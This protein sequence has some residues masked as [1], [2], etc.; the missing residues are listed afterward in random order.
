MVRSLHWWY[1][2]TC[3]C[4]N[5][6]ILPCLPP[7]TT[8]YSSEIYLYLSSFFS[9]VGVILTLGQVLAHG[10]TG[11]LDP[12]F[13]HGLQ[14]AREVSFGLAVGLNY[15][16]FWHFVE[17]RISETSSRSTSTRPCCADGKRR[18]LLGLVLKWSLLVLILVISVLQ[19]TWRITSGVRFRLLYIS[20]GTIEITVSSLLLLKLILSAS[21][22]RGWHHIRQYI[23]PSL[24][25]CISTGLGVGNLVD[26]RLCNS[27]FHFRFFTDDMQN[28]FRR[29][30]WV[31]CFVPWSYTYSL[32]TV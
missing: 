3:N 23:A 1:Q 17:Q 4:M 31:D 18:G 21:L 14:I 16:F 11:T 5:P 26:G 25:L 10:V 8:V 28:C 13:L 6:F 9:F 24:A 7:L 2:G 20:E 19:I 30:P 32:S 15:I 12:R 22:N 29:Q 27:C